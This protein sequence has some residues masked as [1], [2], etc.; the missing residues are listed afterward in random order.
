LSDVGSNR[1]SHVPWRATA[2]AAC[3]LFA[4]ASKESGVATPVVLTTYWWLFRRGEARR[5]WPVALGGGAGLALAFLAARF[6]LEPET[7]RIF[8]VKPEYP[9]GSLAAALALE[10]R[11]LALYAQLV[12]C[13]VN[14]CAD[15]GGPSV[16]HLTLP[17]AIV[18]VTALAAVLAWGCWRDRRIAFGT[19]LML[20]PLVPVSNLVP[21][22][23][24]AADRYLYLP[25]AGVA[26]IV[27]CVVATAW[28]RASR[29]RRQVGLGVGL[30][31]LGLLAAACMARQRV[32][33]NSMA[34][35]TDTLT[36]NPASYSAASGLAAAFREAGQFTESERAARHALVLSGSSRGDTWVALALAL[37]GQ[38]R[39]AD[40]DAAVATALEKD[41]RLADPDARVAAL[42]LERAEA[43]R[44]QA[45]LARRPAQATTG[46]PAKP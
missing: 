45:L 8:D 42:A 38:G 44:L 7:S 23:R 3:C 15:Y 34:L 33:S 11:I 31:A 37:E 27:A 26:V 6:L 20:L 18:I 17:L 19:A 30:V 29:E 32:W 14:L 43:D 1:R 21:I 46:T 36:R 28:S 5:F 39:S 16:G 9:G 10:P 4:C 25:L 13:P 12:V 40:A 22:Y 35:W 24:A 41:P 2:C